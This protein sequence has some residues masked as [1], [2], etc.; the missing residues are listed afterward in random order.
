LCV[1]KNQTTTPRT[2][3]AAIKINPSTMTSAAPCLRWTAMARLV[4]FLPAGSFPVDAL[5]FVEVPTGIRHGVVRRLFVLRDLLTEPVVHGAVVGL[6]DLGAPVG[7]TLLGHVD[8]VPDF[9]RFASANREED[10]EM[11]QDPKPQSTAE[12]EGI[13]DQQDAV[14]ER[15]D[16]L[17]DD[18]AADA[19]AD[20]G[21]GDEAGDDATDVDPMEGEAPTG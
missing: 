13:V 17:E 12:R 19:D 9:R 16:R 4:L 7:S 11:T 2:T 10:S 20:R 6:P 15:M 1:P 21:A 3:T 8:A 18:D 14:L 5:G